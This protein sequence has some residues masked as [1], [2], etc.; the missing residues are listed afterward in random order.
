MSD[1]A[2]RRV[3]AVLSAIFVL[4]LFFV[5]AVLIFS[6]GSATARQFATLRILDGSVQVLHDSGSVQLAK[7]G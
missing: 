6:G 3:E 4:S 2:K 7:E 5:A 1:K